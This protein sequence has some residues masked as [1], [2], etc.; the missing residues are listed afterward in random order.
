M[1]KKYALLLAGISLSIGLTAQVLVSPNHLKNNKH[2]R[3]QW[4]THKLA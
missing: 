2:K 1:K 3:I 4:V